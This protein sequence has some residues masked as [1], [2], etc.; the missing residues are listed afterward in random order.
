M[1][2]EYSMILNGIVICIDMRIL[3]VQSS[4]TVSYF[5]TLR[6]KLIY[7]IETMKQVH[8]I[9]SIFRIYV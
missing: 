1:V 7:R 9:L 8:V 3:F 6:G 5:L 4:G 2:G